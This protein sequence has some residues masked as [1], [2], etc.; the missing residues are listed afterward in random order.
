MKQISRDVNVKPP[1]LTTLTL[2]GYSSVSAKVWAFAQMGLAN[3][4]LGKTSGLQFWKLLGTGNGGGFSLNPNWSRYGLLAVWETP[5]AADDFFDKSKLMQKYRRR[6]DEIWTV[7]MLPTRA[8]GLWS[9]TNPFPSL[10]EKKA[11]APV[12]VLTRAKI[13]WNKLHRFWSFVPSTSRELSAARNLIASIG[14]GEAPFVR[15]ATFSLWQSE[16]DVQNFAYKSPVH[17]EVVK[18]TRQEKWYSE[19]LFAR[20]TPI[21]SE[22]NWN[23]RNPLAGLLND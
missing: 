2:F 20:F 7:K 4:D 11:D 12:A 16:D 15:Q 8:H 19:D 5:E 13:H 6:A 9:G 22:G 17:R 14:I 3:F 1:P 21:A 10:A 23:G 18:L